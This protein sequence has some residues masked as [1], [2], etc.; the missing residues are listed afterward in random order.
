MTLRELRY[1]VALAEYGHFG[2][3][4]EACH[5]TQP[6]LSTQLRKLEDELG[7][8]LFE[9]TN[10]KLN[11]TPVGRT[12]VDRARRVL[13]EADALGIPLSEVPA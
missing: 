12:I 13:A 10:K 6:T 4:A 7:V 5:V 3:A 2:R 1:L 11:I 8:V 9:R